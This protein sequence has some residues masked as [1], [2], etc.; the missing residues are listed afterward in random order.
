M[1]EE[2]RLLN[3]IRLCLSAISLILIVMVAL[4]IPFFIPMRLDT[5]A[6][7]AQ[8]DAQGPAATWSPPDSLMI[9]LSP[10]GDLIRYGRELVSHTAVYLGPQGSVSN[11][12][13]GMNC[14]NC[15]LKAGRKIFGNNFSAVASTYPK[16]RPR[17]GTRESIEKRVN[18]C[19]ER[20]LNGKKLDE[21]SKEMRAFV[22]YIQWVGSGIPKDSVPAGAGIFDLPFLDRATDPQRGRVLYDAHCLRCHGRD[23][24]GARNP[25]GLEWLYP[26]LWGP[27]SYNTGAGIFRLSRMAGYIKMNMPNEI[28]ADSSQLRDEEAWDIAA[29]VNTM[30]R[31][32]KDLAGDWPDI[33]TK[34]IDHPFGPYA[35]KF[36]EGQHKY[37]PFLPIISSHANTNK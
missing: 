8:L 36:S 27:N 15:H 11:I 17:S 21:D 24:E 35:D 32:T 19:L 31:P 29:F 7:P 9:P 18:D 20:S 37:G 25:N 5:D 14:Q 22:S 10:E 2:K 33:S 4:L 3:T 12:S 26:P 23:G 30:P 16:F 13:N 6:Q 34:P 28:P 1:D